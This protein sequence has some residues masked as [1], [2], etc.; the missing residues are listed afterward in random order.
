MSKAPVDQA[1]PGRGNPPSRSSETVLAVATCVML[2]LFGML[3][4]LLGTFFYD[5]GP[6]PL[7]A[8]GFDLGILATCLL[9]G[10]GMGRALG[11]VLPAIGWFVVAFTLASGTSGGSVLITASGPGELF[12]FGGAACATAGAIAVLTIWSRLGPGRSGRFP[13]TDR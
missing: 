1:D 6:A 5:V 2:T 8:I 13:R 11:G 12:L 10:W 3:Q 7:A 4:A 9:G